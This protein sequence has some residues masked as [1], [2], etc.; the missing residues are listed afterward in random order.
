MSILLT[1]DTQ[2]I[3]TTYIGKGIYFYLV[4]DE[5]EEVIEQGKLVK[6]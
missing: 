2:Q 5:A 1:T 6:P 3:T 4:V